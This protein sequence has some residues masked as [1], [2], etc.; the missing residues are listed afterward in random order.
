[1]CTGGAVV[2]SWAVDLRVVGS[3]HACALSLSSLCVSSVKLRVLENFTLNLRNTWSLN[4]RAIESCVCS[5][6]SIERKM[7]SI[8]RTVHLRSATQGQT[9]SGAAQKLSCL[10]SLPLDVFVQIC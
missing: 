9:R 2:E 3:P 8:L 7:W 4:I 10:F 1:M 5:I 6:R